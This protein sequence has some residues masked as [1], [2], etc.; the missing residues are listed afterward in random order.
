MN[1]LSIIYR[2]PCTY[3]NHVSTKAELREDEINYQERVDTIPKRNFFL[4]NHI[5]WIGKR[6]KKKLTFNH[7]QPEIV[8]FFFFKLRFFFSK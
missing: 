8:F 7:E 4:L 5:S 1:L 2:T 3:L 6:K